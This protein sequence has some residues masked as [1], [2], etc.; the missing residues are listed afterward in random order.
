M[1]RVER[2]AVGVCFGVVSSTSAKT[3]NGVRIKR[4]ALRL[5]QLPSL[6][7]RHRSWTGGPTTRA[8][9]LGPGACPV[10][11]G[12]KHVFRVAPN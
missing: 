7:S 5:A 2:R 11:R 4:S 10:R 3:E 12:L 8:R 1:S 6:R 9:P